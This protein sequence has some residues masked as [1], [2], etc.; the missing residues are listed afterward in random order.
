MVIRKIFA[1]S[2]LKN[3]I[4]LMTASFF[5][6]VLGFFFWMIAARYYAPN[7]VGITSAI[8]STVSLISMISLIGFPT[9]LIFY[10]PRDPKSVNK[11][12]NSCLTICII[13]SIFSSLIFILDIDIWTPELKL[14]SND[15]DIIVIF[16]ITT[17]MT[18]V[19][20]LI[21][22]AFT[23]G[24]R[25]SF[26]MIKENIFG[27]IKIFPL[28]F[29]TGLGTI[30]IFL[31]WSVG[32]IFSMIIGFILLSKLWKYSPMFTFDPII[33][34]MARFSAGNYIS[35]IFYSLP[36]LILPIMIMSL[37]S[38]E[39]AGYFFIAFTMAGLLYGISQSISSSFLAESSDKDKFWNNAN[40]AIKFNIGLL[41]PGLLLFMIFGKFIL[42]IFN[43]QYAEN[44]T[45]SLIILVMTSVP[46]SLIGI[47]NAVRNAQGKV[48][49]IIKTNFL[50]A[51]ITLSL[52]IPLMR[53][54]NIEGAAISYLVANTIVSIIVVYRMKNSVGS[55]LKILN[56]DIFKRKDISR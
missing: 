45:Y 34:N 2:L 3:S 9:A 13:I 49:S 5:N 25:S 40:K 8:L 37:I 50:V 55:T 54:W 33:K 4:Y 21:S 56:C 47:F 22:G 23:A 39:S 18:T 7:D 10:L 29:F 51:F 32:L 44:A 36:R 20:A 48:K 14:I 15:I 16:I 12:I 26:H 43:S 53:T 24:R 19:S 11:I 28:V 38:A 46:L 6:S 41:I 52:A 42:N 1:D 35:G 17:I 30:G 31:S 27:F